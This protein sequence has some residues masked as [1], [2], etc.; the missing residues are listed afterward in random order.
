MRIV[1]IR[2][3]T[4]PISRYSDLQI[5]SDGLNTTV[6]AII[7]DVHRN[8]AP[9]AGFGF[10]SIGRFGQS[11]LICE[12]FAPR[13]IAAREDELVTRSG[14]NLDPFRAWD[15]MMKGEKSGGHGER[16][17]AVG[18]MD[19]ALWDAAAKIAEK[20]LYQFLGE[21]V[22]KPAARKALAVYAGGGY[23]FPSDDIPRLIDEVRQFLDLGYTHVKIKIAGRSLGED[24]KRIEAVLSLLPG[25][26]HLAAD[27]MNRYTSE[28]AI[29]AA[30]ALA[31]YKLRWFEDMCDPLDFETHA[32]IA[33]AYDQPLGVGEALFSLADT[34]NLLRYGGLRPGR[35][36]LLFDPAHC[37]GLP[38]YL[39]ILELLESSG[40]SL[41]SCQPHGGHLFS[42]H[43][44]AALGLG[45]CESNPHN[46]QPFGGFADEATVENGS[47][48][49]PEAPGIGFE[50]R[51]SLY[52]VFRSL[53][54]NGETGSL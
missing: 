8:G 49:P 19:M 39:R 17:V 28:S 36:V 37:Y 10:S 11:G 34:R 3:Q 44:A 15:C 41:K 23:Y 18:T 30:Q 16:C 7:T 27:A 29:R 14:D 24:L 2:E 5:P 33:A 32:R 25:G 51:A 50:T 26:D 12:R 35:D 20:P 4:I 43:V 6:V 21:L 38:E 53:L 46:F 22:G 42:L 1:E 54:R 48:Q 13:L 9:I 47:V 52:N 31:P 45:G 40:W